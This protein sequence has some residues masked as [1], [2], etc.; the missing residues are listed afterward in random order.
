MDKEKATKTLTKELGERLGREVVIEASYKDRLIKNAYSIYQVENPLMISFYENRFHSKKS[1]KDN[2][3]E[4]MLSHEGNFA[5]ANYFFITETKGNI[6]SS[7]SPNFIVT[8]YAIMGDK[9]KTAIKKMFYKNPEPDI[10]HAIEF[11]GL[12]SFIDLYKQYSTGDSPFNK[13][14]ADIKLIKDIIDEA[15]DL[16]S[17]DYGYIA[18]ERFSPWGGIDCLNNKL[19][20]IGLDTLLI[21]DYDGAVQED[22]VSGV[23][24]SLSGLLKNIKTKY[25][26]SLMKEFTDFVFSSLPY[27]EQNIDVNKKFLKECTDTDF[28]TDVLLKE[29]SKGKYFQEYFSTLNKKVQKEVVDTLK[30]GSREPSHDHF[31]WSNGFDEFN[32]DIKKL[33]KDDPDYF[34]KYFKSK[35]VEE[36]KSI[37][38]QIMDYDFVN[39]KVAKF[40]N[41]KYLDLVR[42]VGLNG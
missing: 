2:I 34:I 28:V 20:K 19:K 41:K 1:R 9:E 21:V 14:I 30:T 17:D 42:E 10:T 5:Q 29:Y 13:I 31:L 3:P 23:I 16:E 22:V 32:F 33:Y 27:D 26:D 36:K 7:R 6:K 39:E 4:L 40:L 35:S 15:G 25:W 18:K 8:P 12:E 37:L 38:K 11:L 24:D